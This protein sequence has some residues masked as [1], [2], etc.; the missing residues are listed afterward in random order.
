MKRTLITLLIVA[1]AVGVLFVMSNT[2]RQRPPDRPDMVPAPAAPPPGPD[3]ETANADQPATEAPDTTAAAN[4]QAETTHQPVLEP[5]GANK[6]D[7]HES[8]P[9]LP[10]LEAVGGEALTGAIAIGDSVDE[11]DNPYRLK[12]TFSQWGASI[13]RIELARYSQVVYEHE[14]YIVQ[15][16]VDMPEVGVVYPMV[17]QTVTVN[18][19]TVKLFNLRWRKQP[20]GQTGD[21]SQSVSFSAMVRTTGDV[22]R[23]ILRITRTYRVVAGRYDVELAQRFE[24]L[25]DGPL[26]VRFS[27]L[28]QGDMPFKANYMGDRRTLL[29]GYLDP[30]Y[31]P[32]SS[33][34]FTERFN[35]T[36]QEV[37]GNVNEA[38]EEG[39][40]I[41]PLW[42]TQTSREEGFNLVWAAMSNRYFTTALHRP[43]KAVDQADPGAW[44]A[45][46][47]NGVVARIRPI[48]RGEDDKARLILALDSQTMRLAPRPKDGP[49]P[50][51]SFDLVLYAGPKAPDVID[52]DARYTALGMHALIVYNLGGC[53]TIL[54]FS[55]L[56]E[57]LLWFLKV[58]QT[59]LR[60][61]GLAIIMLVLVVRLILHPLTKKSQINMMKFGKQ[62]QKLQPE[63]QRLK[64]KYKDNQSKLNAEMM[65]LYRERGV[66]PAAMGLGCLPMFLQMPIWIA[67]YAML[68]FAIELRHEPA[69]FDV[70]HRIGQAFGGNWMFLSD[71]SSADHFIPLGKASF[72]IPLVGWLVDAVNILPILMAVVFF[73]QQKFMSGAQGGAAMTDQQRQQQAMMK[74]MMPILFPIMLYKAPSGLTLYI[75]ASTGAGIIDSYFV[76]KH[77]KEQEESGELFKPKKKSGS[78]FWARMQQAAVER[79]R[80]L[81]RQ[82]KPGDR[83][84]KRK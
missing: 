83:K 33:M 80:Q 76:R 27:Q 51:E 31:D 18:N 66:N 36:R 5:T 52:T 4:R 84:R 1:G 73:F 25:S 35:L 50:A 12:A 72:R 19:R 82:K 55:W 49:A 74:W 2:G 22:P 15:Q 47:L 57:G 13:K 78:G 37:I 14:P 54:T 39:E 7:F 8:V 64:D 21:V 45:Q 59:G 75:L 30:G 23:D 60:D 53:C 41:E 77:L 61:W 48:V 32:D 56:A 42:P 11:Q 44:K 28:A 40:A 10:P 69:F 16:I 3:A 24:N 29:M 62:M 65:K 26:E 46:P 58:L 9:D 6:A 71:L 38:R 81:E 20:G 68:F 67:L 34:V 70:F 43:L 79:Q 63:I 17:A